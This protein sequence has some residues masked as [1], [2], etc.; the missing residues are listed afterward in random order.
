MKSLGQLSIQG[1][2]TGT[3]LVLS[4]LQSET[5][6]YDSGDEVACLR[7]PPNHYVSVWQLMSFDLVRLYSDGL[8]SEL[9]VLQY[10]EV[11]VCRSHVRR[12]R[13]CSARG[14]RLLSLRRRQG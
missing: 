12:H 9:H 10:S 8:Q 1:M 7:I 11:T 4:E 5:R 13:S 6:P 14:L 3:L 2:S